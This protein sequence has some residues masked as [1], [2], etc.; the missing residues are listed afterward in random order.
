MKLMG[1]AMMMAIHRLVA[2]DVVGVRL[3]EERGIRKS[4]VSLF[5]GQW[6]GADWWGNFLGGR[7]DLLAPEIGE[8]VEVFF[9]D[10]ANA[11]G[12]QAGAGEVA[13]IGLVVDF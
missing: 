12:V 2:I 9:D 3:N 11:L 6:M 8:G 13:V 5:F 4:R 1:L 10:D 7:G